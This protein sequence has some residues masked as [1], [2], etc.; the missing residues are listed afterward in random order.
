MEKEREL[1]GDG[2]GLDECEYEEIGMLNL[3][4]LVSHLFDRV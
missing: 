4:A 1:D 2:E 3:V